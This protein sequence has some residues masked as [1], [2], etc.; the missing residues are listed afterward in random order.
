MFSQGLGKAAWTG[1]GFCDTMPFVGI[2]KMRQQICGKRITTKTRE[3]H[4]IPFFLV[5]RLLLRE[6]EKVWACLIHAR[7]LR[8]SGC[9]RFGYYA[10]DG[11]DFFWTTS[12]FLVRELSNGCHIGKKQRDVI[13]ERKTTCGFWQWQRSHDILFYCSRG[14]EQ[15]K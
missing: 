7:K 11:C 2:T 14:C 5:C 13:R 9:S 1:V 6:S 8:R 3:V 12:V 4:K 10:N 15:V